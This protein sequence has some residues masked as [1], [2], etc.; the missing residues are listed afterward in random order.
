M[1]AVTHKSCASV[2]IPAAP[3][4][5]LVAP[6]TKA[7]QQE[8]RVLLVVPY[9]LLTVSTILFLIIPYAAPELRVP[10]MA[11]AAGAAAWEY[12]WWTRPGS[13]RERDQ[14]RLVVYL[15]GG[16]LLSAFL[17]FNG[18]WFAFYAWTFYLRAPMV[19]NAALRWA[20]FVCIATQL[21][22]SQ[23]GGVRNLS[24]GV[25]I[26]F[27]G[28][29]L[30]NLAVA[31]GMMQLERAREQRH[32]E[33]LGELRRTQHTNRQLEATLAENAALQE[34]V[35]RQARESGVAEERA[36]LA[37]EIHDTIAQGLAG[38]VAQLE[39]ARQP[40]ADSDRHLQIAHQLARESL[41][42]ARRS[43]QALR[44]EALVGPRFSD[45]LA[46][47]AKQW[48]EMHDVPV[49]YAA[50]GAPRSLPPD[51][52]VAL[53]RVAQEA[54]ANIAKH[55]R[56]SAVTVSL[57]YLDDAVALD[58]RDDGVGFEVAAPPTS[59]GG[60]GIGVMHERIDRLGGY[61]EIESQTGEGTTVSAV[62]PASSEELA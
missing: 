55:A 53:F 19:S 13:P 3:T 18:P 45:A 36:R 8:E 39:A 2:E 10:V 21:A 33:R 5:P 20:A 25:W 23:V 34:E 59:P 51:V 52:E 62:V 15:A 6:Q 17:V 16:I 50:T 26:G 29:F 27:A 7:D 60:Y 37:R 40:G 12:F 4:E 54:L 35:A 28:L 24:S 57:A 44:P 22:T 56:A 14:Q 38:V 61:F 11:A 48:S 46:R 32:E 41:G 42:E 58:V 43:V 31:A 9:L 1:G 30:V 49:E 47:L